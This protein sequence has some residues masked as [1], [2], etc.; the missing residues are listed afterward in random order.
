MKLAMGALL[1]LAA[2]GGFLQIPQVTHVL[3]TFMEPTFAD[4]ALYEEVSPSDTL[5]A[6]GLVVGAALGVLGIAIAYVLW[7]RNPEAPAR[8][9]TRLAPLHRLFSH[10]WYFD[11]LIDG[12]IVRPFA[13]FGRFARGTFERLVVNGLFVGG[14]SGAVRAGSS[15]VRAAQSGFLRYYA[16]LLLLGLAALGVYF[17]LAAA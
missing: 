7:V 12:L 14:T 3:D 15:A 5:T 16:A 9:R 4:S 2:I 6:V 1:V 13:W 10:K 11:E 17:L 8:I